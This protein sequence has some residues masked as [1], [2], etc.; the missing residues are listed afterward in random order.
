[1]EQ[2]I[3][4]KYSN[5]RNRALAIRTDILQDEKQ[6]RAVRKVP[7]FIEGEEHVLNL[8][9][10]E[11]RLTEKYKD[12]FIALNHCEREDKSVRFEYLEGDTLETVLDALYVEGKYNQLLD[13][14]RQYVNAIKKANGTKKFQYTDEFEAVF[15]SVYLN[16]GLNAADFSNIDMVVGNVIINK[17][18]W[19]IIDYEWSFDFPIPVNF[20][21]FRTIFY[22]VYATA[23][24]DGLKEIGFYKLFG[25]SE[26]EQEAYMQMEQ[27]FQKYIISEITPIRDMYQ[28]VSKGTINLNEILE[29]RK[30]QEE[31]KEIKLYFDYGDG[32][33]EKDSGWFYLGERDADRGRIT[34]NMKSGLSGLRIDPAER[35]C[36]VKIN[37]IEGKADYFYEM[38]FETN[39]RQ[40]GENLYI[41]I[42]EDPWIR[43]TNL[44]NGTSRVSIDIEKELISPVFATGLRLDTD[45]II[46]EQEE[47]RLQIKELNQLNDEQEKRINNQEQKINDQEQVLADLNHRL[48]MAESSFHEIQ[49]SFCWKITKPI[50][51]VGNLIRIFLQ[52]HYAFKGFLR[53]IKRLFT[54]GF[55]GMREFNRKEQIAKRSFHILDEISVTCDMAELERQRKEV[56]D[57]PIKFSVV[58]PLYNTP[59]I[60]LRKMIESA[61]Y[62]TYENLELCLV[63]GSDKAHRYVK[64]ICKEYYYYDK[65]IHYK[66]LKKNL[67][68]SD[69]TNVCLAMSQGDYIVL[70]DHDD[71][72][73][74]AAL[75]ENRKAI[76]EKK[77][78]FLYSDENTFHETI[79]DAFNPHYKP[80][81]APDTLRSNNYI[82]H[83][84]VFSRKLYEK[85]GG[86]RKD[87]DGS[88]DYDMILRLTEQADCIVHIPKI[89]YYWRAHSASVAM[90]IHA[91][92][93][94]IISAKKALSEHLKRMGMTGEVENSMV[95]STY[96]IKYKLKNRPL[97]SIL[98]PNCDHKS[99]LEKCLNSL[100][101]KTTYE[102][103][104]IIIIENNSTKDEIV[105]YYKEL[106]KKHDNLKVVVWKGT[107]NYAAI[108]N[109]GARFA[110]GEYLLLLNNDVEIITN[111]WIEEMLMYAQ[112][113]EVG[114]VGVK[115][116]YPDGTLQHMGVYLGIGGV[117]GH[118]MKGISS[119][120]PG[121]FGRASFTQNVSC[122]TAACMM[123]PAKV[124]REIGGFD[125][126][127]EVAFNDVD[128]CMRIR[129]AGYLI[130]VT[131]YAELYHYESKSRGTDEEPEKRARFVSEVKRFQAQWKR[132]LTEGDPYY[133]P[134]LSL[135]R[136]DYSI[137][138]A[139]EV[140][141]WI[142]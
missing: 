15:G 77:A 81:F 122:V 7:L 79:N 138:E 72:L 116:L 76:E 95:I 93:Y 23:K 91:K 29:I 41:F 103:F 65:R 135:V 120:D 92:D 31:E 112:R 87:F 69:N 35:P 19:N 64:N 58:V 49:G 52:R 134:N 39:A 18:I 97:I 121:Y 67:G 63:D 33:S 68:I 53:N 140:S 3:Y 105:D 83:L 89:L 28:S 5:E 101:E 60:Y 86:F 118:C 27:N 66:K 26:K 34:I 32:F 82:C 129:K 47:N 71:F 78:D 48:Y 117:A 70:F 130:V 115:L 46:M 94:C 136:Y 98:I 59:E 45:K 85:V 37:K 51:M 44:R 12:T 43:I 57:K 75:Y 127:Y 111:G 21:I 128:L 36:L 142:I 2:V 90:N 14:F 119:E 108:N 131:P 124:F 17:D 61:L 9:E 109:F 50:R 54:M 1:M 125:E 6:K 11:E 74:P 56:F 4:S 38:E 84:T 42:D 141:L 126:K 102:N 139:G 114:A 106:E 100:Y 20:I 30:K 55:V 73:H 40:L 99:D 25:I 104:E 137:K 88:Q 132:E 96:R 10:W 24:R 110:K 80:D 62:Q 123:I 113:E 8:L 13:L 133:N 107:F 16:A 22:Y